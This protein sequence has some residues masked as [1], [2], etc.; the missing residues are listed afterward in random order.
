MGILGPRRVAV[1]DPSLNG[2]APYKLEDNNFSILDVSDIVMIDPVGTGISRA[3]GKSKNAD[4]WGVDPDI[5]S[6][7]QFIKSYITDNERWNSPKYLLGRATAPSVRQVLQIT[8]SRR[9]VFL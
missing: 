6:L 5:K 2:P 7:S 3:V 4:F 9:W 1:N 8:C